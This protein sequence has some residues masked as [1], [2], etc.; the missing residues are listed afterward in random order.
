MPILSK[1]VAQIMLI[2]KMSL[3]CE[4]LPAV[5]A[6]GA[7][8]LRQCDHHVKGAPM[9]AKAGQA[10]QRIM[11]AKYISHIKGG[12]IDVAQKNCRKKLLFAAATHSHMSHGISHLK[13]GL[14][15][16]FEM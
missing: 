12:L 9:Q 3:R 7:T 13:A 2:Q 11:Q 15:C 10:M 4:D 5:E 14:T 8:K 1:K 16:F 6:R